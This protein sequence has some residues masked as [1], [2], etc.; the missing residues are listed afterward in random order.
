M[1]KFKS[2]NS[3]CLFVFCCATVANSSAAQEFLSAEEL[4]ATIPGATLTGISNED[5]KTRWVQH[6]Q[7]GDRSGTAAGEFNGR[8]Y[9][10]Q[11]SVRRGLW[12]EEWSNRSGCWRME[13]IS[14]TE[15]Q[16]WQGARKLPN[17]WSIVPVE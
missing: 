10:S 14:E 16:P 4:L 12:C 13:R 5:Q 15:L 11:W 17:T 8:S 9:T 7:S 2:T 1:V 3:I 6:Y